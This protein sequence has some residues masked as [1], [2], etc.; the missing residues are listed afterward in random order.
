MSKNKV[1][2]TG[3]G[4]LCPIGHNTSQSWQALQD[5]KSGIRALNVAR[6]LESDESF[7]VKIAGVVDDFDFSHVVEAKA[8]KKMDRFI[9]M[10]LAVADEA[11]KDAALDLNTIDAERF[12]CVIG[13][14]VGGIPMIEDTHTVLQKRGARRVSPFFVPAIIINM[15]A[16]Q[17]SMRYGLKGPSH[18]VVSACATGTHS[19]GEA[20]RMIAYNDADI[21]LAGGSEACISRLT[22]GGFAAA[23]A[24]STRNDAPQQASRP[25]DAKRDGF[26]M[27]EGAGVL[28]LESYAHAKQRNAKIYAQ[29]SGYGMSSDAHHMTMPPPDGEGAARCMQNAL[30]DAQLNAADIGY[31]NAHGT[32]TPAGDIAEINA[33]K[34]VFGNSAD[35]LLISSS[36]SMTG[37]LLGAAGGIEAV[38]TIKALQDQLAPPTINQQQPDPACDLNIVAN[39][40]QA[41]CIEH[42]MSN[43][44]GFGGTNASLLFSKLT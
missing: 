15:A 30:A 14:G 11:I 27:G 34:T 44:F 10:A 38:F 20:A 9:K 24:L 40:A 12:G 3:M 13:S 18:S 37:H 16:G 31:I 41:A 23:R 6:E 1:V 8:A 28:L 22:L 42:A 5:G 36:K 39:R 33:I 26:V 32:S 2:V 35:K 7:A 21:M 17:V 43:S 29:L 25:F 4:C 19:I